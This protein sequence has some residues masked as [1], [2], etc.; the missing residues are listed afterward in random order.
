MI[1]LWMA[2]GP[3]Q[4][5]TFDPHPGKKIAGGTRAINTSTKGVQFAEGLPR[6]AELMD[7]LTIVRSMVS[8]EGDH[9]R[10][11][12]NVKT[13]YRPDPTLVHPSIG[14]VVCHELP[15]AEVDIPLSLIHI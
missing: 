13:G 1:L 12:Y 8:K 6:V 5:E 2:G 15:E 7:E 14:A 4:L 10:A 9:E 3:S 11:T